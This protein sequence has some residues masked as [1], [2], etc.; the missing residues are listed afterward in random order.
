VAFGAGQHPVGSMIEHTMGQPPDGDRGRSHLGE[1]VRDIRYH[2]AKFAFLFEEEPLSAL[3][4]KGNP[5]LG[6]RRYFSFIFFALT[7]PSPTP[8]SARPL[9][10]LFTFNQLQVLTS[11]L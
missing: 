8:T 1:L 9:F 3:Y 11:L 5:L 6:R 7:T 4:L 10:F 2:V